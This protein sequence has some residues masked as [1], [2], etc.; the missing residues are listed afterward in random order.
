[1]YF[2]IIL[3]CTPGWT[4]SALCINVVFIFNESPDLLSQSPYHPRATQINSRVK[5]MSK[6]VNRVNY[7]K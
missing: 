3:Q 5:S 6:V 4:N 1:M 7:V 2:L